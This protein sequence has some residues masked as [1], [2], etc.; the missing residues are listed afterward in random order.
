[1]AFGAIIQDDSVALNT[2]DTTSDI[3]FG[4]NVTAG[5]LIVVRASVDAGSIAVTDSQSNTYAQIDTVHNHANMFWAIASQSAACT[6]TIT[7]TGGTA[8]GVSWATEFEGPFNAVPVHDSAGAD[9]VSDTISSTDLTI[10]RNGVLLVGYIISGSD[11]TQTSDWTI[12][13]EA[14][15]GGGAFGTN[16]YMTASKVQ[17]TAANEDFSATQS[18]NVWGAIAAAFLPEYQI[19]ADSGTYVLTGTAATLARS[20]RAGHIYRVDIGTTFDSETITSYVTLPW[21]QAP[22]PATHDKVVQWLDLTAY[23]KGTATVTVSARFADEPHEFATATF[24]DYGTIGATPDG[25]KGFVYLGVTS[26]WMQVRL[27][28][29]ALQFEIQPPVV[30][31]Y[32]STGRRI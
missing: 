29:T 10:T 12:E 20:S 23:L 24:T 6:V 3:V 9:A 28:A 19:N 11:A 15:V 32:N 21:Q 31:G 18:I 2:V 16:R 14:T 7:R 8:I 17:V 30:I 4:G 26:R 13:Q 25:D 1:M 5:S 27:R 22:N